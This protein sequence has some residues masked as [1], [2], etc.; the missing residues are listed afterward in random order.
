VETVLRVADLEIDRVVRRV[1]R[2]GK[3]IDVTTK[4]LAP[5]DHLMHKAGRRVTRAM[6]IEHVWNPCFDT[7]TNIVD[8]YTNYLR[9]WSIDIVS[10][11]SA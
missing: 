8:A 9:V 1:A 3:Q 7:G 2:G 10:G 4:E 5:L 11:Y 6:I